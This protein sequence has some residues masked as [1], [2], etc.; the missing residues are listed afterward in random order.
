MA[1]I[2]LMWRTCRSCDIFT[3]YI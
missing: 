3:Y 1:Y 2:M